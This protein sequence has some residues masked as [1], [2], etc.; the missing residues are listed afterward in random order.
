M[1]KIVLEFSRDEVE[2]L[3]TMVICE[4]WDK[5]RYGRVRREFL[6]T[7]DEEDRIK[8]SSIYPKIYKWNLV[9]GIP[10]KIRM[11]MSTYNLI[12]RACNFFGTI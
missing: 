12:N 8:L 10:D 3:G 11:K 2:E 5:R 1:P 6:K 7:F 4:M 9:T